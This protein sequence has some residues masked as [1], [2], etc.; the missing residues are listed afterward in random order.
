M[1][2]RWRQLCPEEDLKYLVASQ[3]GREEQL[4]QPEWGRQRMVWV[5]HETAGFVA[6]RIV[7]EKGDTVVVEIVD[8]G[9]KLEISEEMVEKMNPPKYEKVPDMADLTCLNEACVLHNLKARYYSGMI[10][11]Y[12][13]LFCVVINP[14]EKLPIYTE[15]IIEM[16]KGQKRHE[17]PPHVFAIADTAY[18]N[19][20][21]ERDDQSILCTGESG[22][23]KT[24]NTK[25]VIQYLTYVAGTSRTS[26]SGTSQA[27]ELEQQLL[28][29]NPILE[30]FGN[31][32]T[33]KNDN[34]SRF[35]KFI[36]INF[37]MSG[38]IC[39]ANIESYLLEK[40]R[41]N[42][43]A[44]DE[45]SFHIFYQFLQ[46]TTEE[47]KKAFVLNKVDQYRFLA[48]GYIALPGVDDAAEFHNTVR[49]M[50]IMN[51]LD[52][53][54]SAILRVV[55]A[56]L[57]F[58]NLEFIQDKKSDQAMLPDDTVYQKVCR[59]LGLSV[60]ELSKALIRPRIK[61][62]RD[63]VHKSQSKEQ[64]EF[65]VE[66]ISKAC[67]ERLFKWLVH[68]I[69]K[70]LDRTK[71]Q[72]A[73]FIGILDMAGF[74]IF[75]LNSFEQLCINYTNEKLQ[76]LFNHTM[77]ILEQEEYQREGIDWQFIDF[78][79]DLQPTIDL[80]E[81]P[82]GILS[83]LD[84]DCW[85]PK[86]TDKSYTEKL[87][88]NHSKHPKFII[89]DFKAASDFALL[90]YA[91][92]VDYSTKQ[93]L[94]KNM[95]PLNENVVALLQNSSD[96]FV[97]SIWKDAEFAGIGA[98]EVNETTFGVRTKKGMF[99]TV[100]QLYKEQLN[101]LMG[102]LRN[103]TPHFV[104]C[105]IPNY[106]KKNGKLDAML[107][108]EQLRCNGVLEGIR[109]CRAGFP[110][111]IPF[112]EFRHRYEILCP[113]VISRGFMDGKE[114]VKKM[115]EYLDLEPVL[116][117]IGQSKIFFR[118]GILAELEDER[119][120]QLSGLI[121]KF[122]AIC[123][124]VLSRRYYHK[125]VQQ[126]NAIRVIQRNGLAYLKLRHWKWWRLFTKVKPLLQVTNQEE[127]LQHKEEEL[128]RLKDHMQRQDVDIREL[129]KKLQQL[130]EEKAVLVEQLQ[131]ETEA[132]VEADDARLRILQKKNELEEHVNELTARL[133]EEEEKI[134]NAFAEKKRFMMNISDLE[135]QLECEEASR[136]KLEL[137]KTQ[138]ENKLKKAEEALAVLDD[139]HSKLLKEK[140][141]AEERCADVSKKLS[142]EEDRSKSLQKLKVKYEAQARCDIEKLKRK[143]EAEVNDLKDQLS[144]KR[145]QLDELQQQLA[146]REEELAHALAKVDEENASKQNFAKR[147][148]EYEGQVNELQEDLESEKVL[149]VKA[150]KQKRDLAGELES[151][152]AELEETHDHSTIQQE[153]RTKREEEVAH[154]KVRPKA[155][156]LDEEATL[157]EQLLQENKQKYMM[158]I[159]AISDTVEQLRKGKQQAEKTK[160]VLESEVAGL[161]A[162]LNN[163]QMAKQES[164]RR[165]KQVE[166]QLMEAN[167]RLGDLERLKAENSDQL[168]KYQTELENAQ[169]TAEDAETKL[170]SAMKELALV[171]LQSAEL[172]DL[173]QEETRA[174]LLLQNKLRNL[175]NDCALVKE[176]KE[177]LEE[178]KQNAEK[179][180]QA[181]QLQMVEL[182]KKNEEVSVEIM[183]EAKKKAQKEIEIVQKKLQEVMVEKDR[184]ERSK[185]KIQQEVEDLKVE[186]ENLKASHSE[187]EKKQRKFDQQLADERSNSAKLNC[188]LDVAT[189]DIRERETK[190]LSLT[191]ELEELR[192]QLSEAD[193]VKRCMQLELND[194]IS[195]KDNA[196]KNVNPERVH[197]LEKAIRALDD[198]VASQKVHITELED[199][200]QLTEDARLRLEVNLQ[201]L[202]TEHERTLQTK[203]SDANEKRKQLLKQ[204]S[205]L[206]EEL[207]SERHVKTTALNNKRKLEVQLRELEVQLEASNRVKEDSGKQLKKIMQQWKEV[208]RELEE[209]RQLR[210][211]G[212]ATIRELEK[213]I[214][215]AESDAAAAQSQLENAVS[216][217]KVAESE[218]DELFDQL[219][220]VN[221][222][223]ALSTE[224]RR[225]FEEKIRALEEE[226]EDE[227]NSLELSNEKLRKAHMQV[228]H[229]SSELASE[230]ANSNNMESVRDS[231]ERANRE[232]KEKLVALETGQRN[233]IKTLTSALELKIADLESKLSTE[234]S[235]RAVMNRLLK[236]TE[237]RFAD[238]SAQ[239]E[240]DRRQFEQL[241]DER[242][243]NLNRIKQMKRQLAENDD[244]IA[245]M[246]TKCRKAVRDV[247]ELTI[248]NEALLKENSNLRSRL[249]RV[250]DQSIKPAAY[251][252][253]G[254]GMLNRTGSTDLLDMSDGSLASREGSLPDESNHCRRMVMPATVVNLS[255]P[256]NCLKIAYLV[257]VRGR[258]FVVN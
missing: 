255:N 7:E 196:G 59:L 103:S 245:K 110:N 74:E 61:V 164:D 105:I 1:N 35:G 19:M 216:A 240:E 246:H 204:I 166:A 100:S 43:Q 225:R 207:E 161:T 181:L 116:Y 13:G 186:F 121:A 235:E 132:C 17:V 92:R 206:E 118:A 12:S 159:E 114:A 215:T 221:A 167:G 214:R 67:Y 120:K 42:R 200:L 210:D 228:D 191:K 28:Q 202:R 25:K 247:E 73:S 31:A 147:L 177:E 88:A 131:A 128:Q 60:S 220:E 30:A 36:R 14:Y 56:V 141:Y 139:T 243:Q 96:P 71:R 213:R 53:E 244:E 168:A 236:K 233:K 99:R 198:T 148:R 23:G 48:N 109:I 69:N 40:S 107:V 163:A 156:M 142:D 219:H 113:N 151:L 209:T 79:L 83:L 41:A 111:R 37:D 241:K 86:A 185:K 183:E 6:A 165:R 149:R 133:E 97:V 190:I 101:R 188:E 90:H 46:G 119:D 5:P 65:S 171:Q 252:F 24:E 170:T 98:T 154:L 72:S 63:Y 137:E 187:M 45:R 203:E 80:I 232:L 124:G 194:F 211:D 217:R 70:S 123:R 75:N 89:P 91:G 212:L 2:D 224:E 160:S 140:K 122:Q 33:V 155:K 251:G 4:L 257:S 256:V 242:E 94:M 178:G 77:F 58:G 32:K 78:G 174:K 150:E 258:Q 68:R 115:V 254:S 135:N 11:T 22:A 117:R 176:Q 158:Q 51:F 205:E 146:R 66:A 227:S 62:G 195:S 222:R 175:E 250:P 85:F 93:W 162:D 112:Q 231:L 127:R 180:I 134:Q 144:E 26:K 125:R 9:K 10:Y 173:L 193:R 104:R 169:K 229:L 197:E 129:E 47:E 145:H 108:L 248:A 3:D 143:L 102:L 81:K 34:S 55:S 201:A 44:K 157:R 64:A 87:K 8:T 50:R 153:L 27:G 52:D 237:R 20:L 226:L 192:E 21:Q 218:R 15:S 57:H 49:S 76:Q 249:R 172:Q 152:K 208:C 238:L 82:M 95:D 84:E 184:V 126:F 39:G 16:Y 138:I 54:I 106:E 253:R 239:V 29:A 234:S 136:Q 182:K 130:I 230:K 199:A 223:G 38:F 189:Q 18:R 179:T